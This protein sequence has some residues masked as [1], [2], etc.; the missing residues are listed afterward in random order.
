[1][2]FIKE[3]AHMQKQKKNL[4]NVND[5]KKQLITHYKYMMFYY[6]FVT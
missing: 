4:K 6:T 2:E 1:M 5:L 3:A